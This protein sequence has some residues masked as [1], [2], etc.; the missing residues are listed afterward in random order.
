MSEQ[1]TLRV[2][3]GKPGL[4]PHD[5]GAKIL[6]VALRDA[7]MEVIYTGI[8]QTPESIASAA[9]QEDVDVILLS[10]LSGAHL[11]LTTRIVEELRTRGASDIP[12]LCGGI[13][14]DRDIP[15]LKEMGV[16]EVFGPMTPIQ[17]CIA[18]LKDNIGAHSAA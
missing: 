3:I 5:R 14:P 17:T 18:Y 1:H 2:L 15:I 11:P 4:D 12:I 16:V 8:H 6:A 13:I 9:V 7:G 10:I